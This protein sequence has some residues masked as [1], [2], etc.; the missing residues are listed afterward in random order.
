MARIAK[1]AVTRAKVY[2]V[3]FKRKQSFLLHSCPINKCQF[4]EHS[5]ILPSNHTPVSFHS[6]ACAKNVCNYMKTVCPP[7]GRNRA[8][9]FS[10]MRKRTSRSRPARRFNYLKIIF[11]NRRRGLSVLF[12]LCLCRILRPF[13]IPRAPSPCI[14]L[15]K[16]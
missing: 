5:S 9:M 6:F 4:R 15:Y 1:Y 13:P 2:K 14:L 12:L 11:R 3:N 16:L 10:I 8:K 7:A